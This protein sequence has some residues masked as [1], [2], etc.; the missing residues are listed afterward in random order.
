MTKDEIKKGVGIVLLC[1]FILSS[2]VVAKVYVSSRKEFKIAEIAFSEGNYR[3]AITH[4]ERA[5]LWYLP[6]GG[7]VEVSA[8]Q[9]WNIAET[10]EEKDKILSLEAYRS[11]RSAFYATRSFYTPGQAWI[12]RANPKIAALMAEQTTYSEADR[13]KSL[14]QKTKEALAILEKPMKPDPFW[15]IVLEI[16]FVGWVGGVLLFIWKA[17]REDGHKIIMKRGVFW[18]TIVVIFYA[19]WIIG[20]MKA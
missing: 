7:Y 4:Y 10:L 8:E 12:D 9:L 20:M 14:N 5:M 6:V 13:K 2:L 3:T 1:I 17:F 19:L 18:G 15:S 16:G 11:L